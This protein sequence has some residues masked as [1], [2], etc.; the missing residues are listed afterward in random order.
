MAKAVGSNPTKLQQNFK[1][2]YGT[3]VNG[4]TK[5]A[6]LERAAELLNL[7]DKS[8]SEIVK[9]VG[10]INRGYFSKLKSLVYEGLNQ[11]VIR[12]F[13]Q[14]IVLDITFNRSLRR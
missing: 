13:R 10:L 2:V 8:I 12:V 14:L 9:E 6:R 1:M 4:Y 11:I 3:T 5:N 7:T